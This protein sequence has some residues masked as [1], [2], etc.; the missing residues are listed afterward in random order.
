MTGILNISGMFLL[1]TPAVYLVTFRHLNSPFLAVVSGILLSAV[2]V[3][4]L[5][6]RIK[7]IPSERFLLILIFMTI[8]WIPF[9]GPKESESLEK[10][11]LEPF[12]Q[13]RISNVW[14]FFKG[15]TNYFEDRYAFR[16]MIIDFYG[17]FRI[18]TFGVSPVPEVEIGVD[19]W[20]FSTGKYYHMLSEVPFSE[21]ELKLIELNLEVVTKWLELKNIKYYFTIAPIKSR[22]YPDKMTAALQHRSSFSRMNQIYDYISENKNIRSID[23]RKELIEGRE[24]RDTYIGSDTHWNEYGAFLAFE[25]VMKT[26]KEDVPEIQVPVIEEYELDSVIKDKGDLVGLM[27][28]DSGFP[29]YEYKLKQK[30]GEP[31]VLV[32]SVIPG[33]NIHYILIS[34]NPGSRNNHRICIIRDSMSQYWQKFFCNSFSRMLQQ[35]SPVMDAALVTKESPDFVLHEMQELFTSHLM[36]LPVEIAADSIFMNQHFKDYHNIKSKVNVDEVIYF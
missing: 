16:N 11:T 22:I 21:N 18:K 6:Q 15:Y 34:N 7:R 32:D 20:L 31:P 9:T 33:K 19:N 13:F 25:K 2:V 28:L 10:R 24:V 12:P 3:F 36:K 23:L 35:W 5:R 17:K 27:G 8:I 26:F 1:L 14:K 4:A 30:A 29:F